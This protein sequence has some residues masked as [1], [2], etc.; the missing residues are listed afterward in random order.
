MC[1]VYPRWNRLLCK[2]RSRGHRGRGYPFSNPQHADLPCHRPPTAF[3]FRAPPT[4]FLYDPLKRTMAATVFG[5]M[6]PRGRAKLLRTRIR[7]VRHTSTSQKSWDWTNH[8]PTGDV[9]R[10]E[11]AQLAASPRRPLTL[12]D[13]LR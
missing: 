2:L 3:N 7:L 11:V 6:P 1:H 8:E 10:D 13:L 12:A 9:A 4:S 5:A